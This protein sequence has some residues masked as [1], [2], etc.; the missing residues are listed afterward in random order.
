[1]GLEITYLPGQTPLDED[2]K[3]GLLIRSISTVAELNEAEQL[4]IQTAIEW[5]LKR[6]FQSRDIFSETFV[7]ELHKRMYREVWRWA[8]EFRKTD[9][10]IG[11]DK[12]DIPVRLRQ[13]LDDG[14]F[15][16]ADKTFP[17]DESAIRFK[18]R[19]VSVHCFPN[20][21]GRHSRLMA[22][23]IASHVFGNR[24][25][26]W[27]EKDLGRNSDARSLYL[28]ALKKA[29]SGDLTALLEFARS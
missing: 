2:E 13:L 8:G 10:N 24:V 1:M 21:N 7:Q 5:T 12:F 22:D 15:W 29:D 6:R 11:V 18:H 14:Q 23:V 28:Q 4:N 9:K 27:S 17:P 20:G 16:L 19:I 3:E 26:S 25:F